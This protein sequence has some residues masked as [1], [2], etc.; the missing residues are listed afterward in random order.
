MIV[1]DAHLDLAFDI[2]HRRSYGQRRVLENIYLPQFK[3]SNLKLVI[4]SIFIENRYL[5]EA[6]LREA[7]KQMES[8]LQDIEECKDFVLVTDQTSLNE[9]LNTEKI[10]I[11]ISFEGAEPIHTDFE[12]LN[13]FYRLGLRGVGLVWSRRNQMGEGSVLSNSQQEPQYGLS[14]FAEK[15]IRNSGEGG[16]FID[17]AHL[18]AKGFWDSLNHLQHPPFV[19]HSS[20]AKLNPTPR[21]LTDDQIKAVIEKDGFIGLNAMNFTISD[22]NNIP[23]NNHGYAMHLRH[24]VELGGEDNLGFGFDFNDQILEYVPKAELDLLP[25]PAFDVVKGYNDV[26]QLLSVLKE[27]GLSEVQIEKIASKNLIRFLR[28]V[29]PK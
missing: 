6:G 19:S 29:L 27:I 28:K 1:A 21:N 23:E 5:P 2:V 15:I 10:G 22:G 9:V 20:V 4:S 3:R 16:Y 26:P 25:R 13:T 7:L 8:L 14:P 17:L 12:L 11:V 18:N 24:I